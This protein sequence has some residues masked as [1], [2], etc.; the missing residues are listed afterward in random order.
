MI[1]NVTINAAKFAE[2]LE[3]TA[4]GPNG[5]P[6]LRLNFRTGEIQLNGNSTGGGRMTLTNQLLQV[7]DENG[8]LRVRVGIW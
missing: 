7:F 1:G 4:V 5:V 8:R 2:W 6:V 3:S